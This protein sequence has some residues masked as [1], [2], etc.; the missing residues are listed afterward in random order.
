MV[1]S[2]YSMRFMLRNY[3]SLTDY[4]FEHTG[5]LEDV[6]QNIY[7][8]SFPAY[9]GFK[10]TITYLK[11]DELLSLTCDAFTIGD[12]VDKCSDFVDVGLTS[13]KQLFG[14]EEIKKIAK[15]AIDKY[16]EDFYADYAHTKGRD[17]FMT[18]EFDGAAY[19]VN[20]TRSDT[21]VF[22]DDNLL[23]S[24]QDFF[25]NYVSNI[26]TVLLDFAAIYFDEL[27]VGA[28]P[29]QLSFRDFVESEGYDIKLYDLQSSLVD[30]A[31][32]DDKCNDLMIEYDLAKFL[33]IERK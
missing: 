3:V 11:T 20:S 8:D 9:K 28:L 30:N 10:D 17:V 6:E 16:C 23:F 29:P 5:H 14:F 24:M 18:I 12:I 22:K 31:L 33:S 27:E 2:W 25:K 7:D 19:T 4:T 21:V 26:T 15:Q 1:E 32:I 13:V